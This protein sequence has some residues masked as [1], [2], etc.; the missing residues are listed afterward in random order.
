VTLGHLQ[1]SL[2]D[3]LS[4]SPW[5]AYENCLSYRFANTLWGGLWVS[6]QD[7]LQGHLERALRLLWEDA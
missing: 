4:A 6:L 1:H 7:D 2:R 5:G 3:R